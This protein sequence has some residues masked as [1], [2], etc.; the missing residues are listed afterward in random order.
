Q[1]GSGGPGYTIEDEFAEGLSNLRGTI[2]MANTGIPNSGGSQWF[3]NV[4]DNTFLDFDKQPASSKHPVFGRVT[5]GMDIVDAIA[6]VPATQVETR[7]D[8]AVVIE[9][10]VIGKN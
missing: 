2:S 6:N 7:P 5:S 3:I 9:D 8:E 1:W 10:M 4:G